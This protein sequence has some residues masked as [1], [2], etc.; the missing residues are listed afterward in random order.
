MKNHYPAID[1]LASVSRLMTEIVTPEHRDAA[2]KIRNMMS[3]YRDNQDLISI[4]AYKAGSNPD[5]DNAIAH[6]NG[7]NEFLQ[8]SVGSKVDFDETIQQLLK[9][10]S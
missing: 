3:V 7:I 8:Q 9:L 5:L 1:V 4:G 6:I 10:V 2:G